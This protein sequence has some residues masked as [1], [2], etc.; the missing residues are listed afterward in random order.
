M[1]D[2]TDAWCHPALDAG[3][4]I[5]IRKALRNKEFLFAKIFP[6]I[7]DISIC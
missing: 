4:T 2:K 7:F 3:S 5:K 1:P 6:F